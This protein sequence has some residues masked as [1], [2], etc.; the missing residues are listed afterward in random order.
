MSD[1]IQKSLGG[2][3][4]VYNASSEDP[5]EL[6]GGMRGE[7]RLEPIPD[8]AAVKAVLSKVP[9]VRDVV[10]M[11]IDQ[12]LVATGNVIDIALERLRGDVRRLEEGESATR[13]CSGATRPTSAT[14][15]GWCRSSSRSSRRPGPSRTWAAAR[16][17][18]AAG[19]GPT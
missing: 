6:Y 14:C 10:P 15:A 3:L 4:Q 7:S 18:T 1:S 16:P 19:S 13:R 8:F 12:A 5:L 17:P 9:N 2:Q 11:G